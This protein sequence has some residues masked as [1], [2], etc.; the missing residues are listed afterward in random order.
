MRPRDIARLVSV[1]RPPS[2]HGARSLARCVSVDDVARVARRRLPRAVA[3]YLDGG[4]EDESTLRRNGG[5]FGAVEFVPRILRDVTNVELAT[6]LF[7]RELPAPIV[8]GP[9][10]G[11]RL[12]HHEGELAAAQAA[13]DA[14]IPYT[15]STLASTRLED[16]A[17]VAGGPLWF[18][19]YVWG[20]RGVAKDLVARAA[21][22]GYEALVVTADV[23]VR[24]KRE[25]ELHT[26]LTLPSPHLS[27]A[28][29]L[30]AARHPRWW[31]RFL[32]TRPPEFP[33]LPDG[34]AR[35]GS[36]DH[37][38]DGTVTWAD[39]DW[40]RN[41]WSGPLILKGVLHPDDATRA[42]AA[43]VDAIV[44]S[45]HGGR[46]LDHLPA[47]IS[48]LPQVA[49][50]ASGMAVLVDSGVRRGTDILAGVAEGADAVMLGR[51][52][53][54]GLAAAGRAGVA[55]VVDILVDE[56]RIACA[57]TGIT[58]V[59]DARTV[60]TTKVDARWR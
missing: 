28:A 30:D 56:L 53:L 49:A 10:G 22:A 59:A 11:T 26:G 12:L 23:A 4:G 7:D 47:T 5:A 20:D 51:A 18:D 52:Y 6:T 27:A 39:I 16:V 46:Q 19:L 21:A 31:R 60:T 42:A 13:G 3:G 41:S 14:G 24:S 58:A 2:P 34:S 1:R 29:A 50:A 45:N 43:G 33:N 38:F 9:A 25:R 37:L 55:H 44:V 36:I 48:Q 32:T 8:L 35:A 57:L 54:Y 40:I 17:S 15:V